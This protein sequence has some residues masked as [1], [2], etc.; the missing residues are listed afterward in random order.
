MDTFEFNEEAARRL[1]ILY[2][3]PDERGQ[4]EEALRQ[5][6][7]RAGE[8]VIDIGCGPGYLSESISMQVLEYIPDA[9]LGMREMARVFKP[10]GRALA[11][12]TDWDALVC[13]SENPPRMPR[14]LHAWERHCTDPRLPARNHSPHDGC[15]AVDRWRQ[16]ISD[17]QTLLGEDVYSNGLLRLI[18]DFA[19][20]QGLIDRA[21]LEAWSASQEEIAH[22]Q[23]RATRAARRKP[24]LQRLPVH[25]PSIPKTVSQF[26]KGWFGPALTIPVSWT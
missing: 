21:V 1:E 22:R 8:A 10:G 14:V 25:R 16:R 23:H 9:D 18:V 20:R 17:H 3:T 19:R 15:R 6:R 26:T 5:L 7:L 2:S 13:H 12:A 24:T 4:R 11:V